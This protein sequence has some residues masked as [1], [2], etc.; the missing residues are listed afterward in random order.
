MV[1]KTMTATMTVRDKASM[2]ITNVY[3]AYRDRFDA[4]EAPVEVMTDMMSDLMHLAD[5]FG[6]DGTSVAARAERRYLEEATV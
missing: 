1:V 5:A 3:R 6:A 2:R 4:Q